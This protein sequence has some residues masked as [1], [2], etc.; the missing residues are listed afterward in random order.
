[1]L[2]L[3]SKLS[4]LF[5]KNNSYLSRAEKVWNWFFSFDDGYGLMTDKYL[6]STGAIPEHCCNASSTDPF[7]KCHNS[8]IPGTSY[9]QGLLISSSAYLYRRTGNKTYLLV[10]MRAL[11]A[12]LANYTTLE[13]ILIDEPRSYQNYQYEYACWGASSSDPGGDWFSFQGIFMLHLGYFVDLLREDGSLSD[14]MLDRIAT[15]V[16]KTS[17]S[18][19]NKSAVWP[20]FDNVTDACNTGPANSTLNYPKFYWWWGE[21]TTTQMI[22]PDPRIFIHKTELRCYT[23]SESQILEGYFGS[24][25]VCMEECMNYKNCSKYLYQT[26]QSAVPGTDCWIWPYNRTNHYCNLTDSDFNVGIKRPVGASCSGHCNE[27]TPVN[28]SSGGVCYCDSQCAFHLDCCLDYVDLCVP[29]DKQSPSCKGKCTNKLYKA[30]AQPIRGGGYCWC[31]E[32]CNP[33]YSDNNS[34][35]SCCPDYTEQCQKIPIPPCIDARSQG[36]AVNLF[37][38]H[39]LVEQKLKER[40]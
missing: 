33:W 16:E 38:A 10:G 9:N 11:E 4:Y 15:F 24:E 26:D 3:S 2:H 39:L 27:E 6:V 12:I 1:M 21:N 13:G 37:I 36:S 29:E 25:Q 18:A 19:W 7:K 34:D 32:G 8:R 5:P 35:G 17:D 40:V 22:P 28:T 14:D 23:F 20:P 30:L 31:F